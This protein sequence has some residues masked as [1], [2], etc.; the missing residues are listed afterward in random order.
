MWF[1][2]TNGW[3]NQVALIMV[4]LIVDEFNF[5]AFKCFLMTRRLFYIKMTAKMEASVKR[6]SQNYLKKK[7]YRNKPIFN[8]FLLASHAS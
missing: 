2:S 4:H 8:R 5:D 3:M 7:I 6:T 1:G